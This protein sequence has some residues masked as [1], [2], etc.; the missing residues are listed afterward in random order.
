MMRTRLLPAATPLLIPSRSIA[1]A[2]ARR[3]PALRVESR[4]I[5]E[6]PDA[7]QGVGLIELPFPERERFES[8]GRLGG[9]RPGRRLLDVRPSSSNESLSVLATF[10]MWK[11]P[12]STNLRSVLNHSRIER[13][14]NS[15]VL[16]GAAFAK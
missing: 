14:H 11:E 13:Y 12:A 1:H 15:P 8:K 7:A 2:S 10:L 9:E 6:H 4:R 3:K 5:V 16:F